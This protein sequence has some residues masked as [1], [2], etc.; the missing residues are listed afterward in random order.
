[1]LV[2]PN[3]GTVV[4]AVMSDEVG[5]IS[6]FLG[7]PGDATIAWAHFLAGGLFLGRWMYR[8]DAGARPAGPGQ[9]CGAAA[10]VPAGPAGPARSFRTPRAAHLLIHTGEQCLAW[11]KFH[12]SKWIHRLL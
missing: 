11:L 9:L 12:N 8:W 5:T 6:D 4:S 10:H 7:T 2:P 1:M 3:F